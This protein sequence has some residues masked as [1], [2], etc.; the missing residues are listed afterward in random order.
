[1]RPCQPGT[2][3]S[4]LAS[5]GRLPARRLLSRAVTTRCAACCAVLQLQYTSSGAQQRLGQLECGRATS[6]RAARWCADSFLHT[7]AHCVRLQSAASAA[8]STSACPAP[9]MPGQPIVYVTWIRV[10]A[11]QTLA[12]GWRAAASPGHWM[13]ANQPFLWAPIVEE[14]G[15]TSHAS[16]RKPA[17]TLRERQPTSVRLNDVDQGRDAAERRAQRRK[18]LVRCFI[19]GLQRD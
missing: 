6:T 11:R 10:R 2:R 16:R 7:C 1:M 14:R 19:S 3:L 12:L 18:R 8:C 15:R 9:C 5:H 17:H 13:N 4:R